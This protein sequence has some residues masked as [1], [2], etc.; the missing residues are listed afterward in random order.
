MISSMENKKIY[1]CI[2]VFN[3]GK[4]IKE[5]IT[6]IRR[7]GYENIIMVD[8]GSN[9]NT[10]EEASKNGA[11]ALRLKINRGKGAA[12]KTAIEGA[13]EFDADVVVTMDG[14]GQHNPLD[15]EKMVHLLGK[16]YDV[17]LGS[18]LMNTKGMPS[19]KILANRV[20][21][22]ITWYIYGL[23][24]TDSQSGFRAYSKKALELIDTRSD[25][26]EYDSE[27][28]REIHRNK[29]KY[30]E[31]PIEVRYTEYSMGKVEKQ[32]FLNGLKTVYRMIWN[33]IS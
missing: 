18:R 17:V 32:S 10:F 9:D 5:V 6:E 14:D 11:I 19:R 7:A 8:D 4:I 22:F 24:V 30:I 27:I 29:L 20:G 13:K 28:I 15:I 2:P 23:W 21:N 31:I 3:E 16:G 1:I 33:I 26:Y 12:I 25:R